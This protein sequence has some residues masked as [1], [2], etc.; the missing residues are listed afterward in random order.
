MHFTQ[1]PP[2]LWLGTR[3]LET[4]RLILR[5][6]RPSDAGDMFRTWTSDA[7]VARFMRWQTHQSVAQTRQVVNAW[8][9]GYA[10]GGFEWAITLRDGR[11]IGSIG[12]MDVQVSEASGE[13]GYCIA[14]P[15]WNCGYATEALTAVLGYMLDRVGLNRIEA[16]HAV[17][18]P[19]SGRVMEKCGMQRE[20][21]CRQKY[22][23]ADGLADCVHYAILAGDERPKTGEI[24][25]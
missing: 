4:E 9:R 14:R 19:A 17:G 21:L 3:R 20:G 25:R 18:N 13:L 11:L 24:L 15:Y 2:R 5:R 22:Q 6:F 16:F 8:V 23:T 1:R 10:A 12:I 7:V